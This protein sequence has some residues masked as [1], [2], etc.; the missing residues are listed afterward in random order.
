[1][2]EAH[3]QYHALAIGA[4]RA[5]SLIVAVVVLPMLVDALTPEIY[6]SW[7]AITS[8]LALMS[9]A[10]FGIGRSLV[11]PLS[12]AIADGD[13]R[14][15]RILISTNVLLS[16]GI[17]LTVMVVGTLILLLAPWGEFLSLK[18]ENYRVLTKVAV[19]QLALFSGSFL[20]APATYVRLAQQRSA[21]AAGATM[22]GALLAAI[23]T[24]VTIGR[25][26]SIVLITTVASSAPILGLLINAIDGLI[27]A[28]LQRPNIRSVDLSVARGFMRD[29]AMFAVQ[30]LSAVGAYTADTV[31]IGN[32][33]G[34]TAVAQYSVVGRVPLAWSGLLQAAVIPIWPVV[35]A[36]VKVR[37]DA[38]QL[39]RY[40]MFYFGIAA[41]T[42]GVLFLVLSPL[43]VRYLGSGEIEFDWVLAG[44]FVVWVIV[45]TVGA[46][47]SHAVVAFGLLRLQVK[48][49]IAMAGSNVA[50]SVYLVRTTLG[51]SGPIIATVVTYAV[52]VLPISFF[53]VRRQEGLH[54]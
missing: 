30:T 10:D 19:A 41:A 14:T 23:A 6:G 52:I 11:N 4:A 24:V 43:I 12:A 7:A 29:G 42:G 40:A 26:S 47:L 36:R 50:L 1:M 9:F 25:S 54:R 2:K 13:H 39:V 28:P 37:S 35:A 48:V 45:S 51:T 5:V 18:P 49:A 22:V 27:S 34:P 46:V 33:L 3:L 53:A 32:A 8:A 16:T 17:G 15:S 44:V 21:R 20:L 38:V 31:I